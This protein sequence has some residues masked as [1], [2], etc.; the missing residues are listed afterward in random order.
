VPQV[1]SDL[2][3]WHTYLFSAYY[4]STSSFLST[5]LPSAPRDACAAGAECHFNFCIEA[6]F[7]EP[8][9]EEKSVYMFIIIARFS[10]P[11]FSAIT[12]EKLTKPH[13]LAVSIDSHLGMH[14]MLVRRDTLLVFSTHFIPLLCVF[15]A[16]FTQTN[17]INFK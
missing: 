10:L 16:L 9:V 7:A 1:G 8:A 13:D 12:S 17:F 15:Y 2:N 3:A 5:K 14:V 11:N 6:T 4:Y